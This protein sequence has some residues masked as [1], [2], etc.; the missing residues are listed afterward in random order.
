[1]HCLSNLE[2][3][4][5]GDN[6]LKV[7]NNVFMKSTVIKIIIVMIKMF[8]HT[9]QLPSSLAPQSQKNEPNLE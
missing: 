3:Q 7:C 1:M 6:S 5:S 4:R 9:A 8:Y 2:L